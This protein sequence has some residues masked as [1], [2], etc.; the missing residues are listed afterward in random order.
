MLRLAPWNLLGATLILVAGVLDGARIGLWVAALVLTYVG[1]VLTGS[2][3]WR[4]H[5]STSPSATASC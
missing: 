4:L 5:P 2:T 1:A 3:G